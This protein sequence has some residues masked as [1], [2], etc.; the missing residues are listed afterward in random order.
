MLTSC[1]RTSIAIWVVPAGSENLYRQNIV[2]F[3][4]VPTLLL[5]LFVM[6]CNK[7]VISSHLLL[8]ANIFEPSYAQI[9]LL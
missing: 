3:G 1:K 4:N 7:F 2:T 6:I 9:L 5:V 8:V